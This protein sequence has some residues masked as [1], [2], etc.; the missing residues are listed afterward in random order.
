MVMF[1]LCL[2]AIARLVGS[3]T[4]SGI[5]KVWWR[6]MLAPGEHAATLRM[7]V[8]Y[9]VIVMGI[10]LVIVW[11][12]VH[13][14]ASMI[15]SYVDKSAFTF[16][17]C[18]TPTG[19]CPSD[20]YAR[21]QASSAARGASY[22]LHDEELAREKDVLAVINTALMA[23][24]IFQSLKGHRY[25]DP[26]CHHL[27][28][29]LIQLGLGRWIAQTLTLSYT[30]FLVFLGWSGL[31]ALSIV[32]AFVLISF[33]KQPRASRGVPAPVAHAVCAAPVAPQ[34]V[35]VAHA[36]CAAPS[37]PRSAPVPTLTLCCPLCHAPT[38]L[39][40]QDCPD[41]GLRFASRVPSVLH[42]LHG[43]TVLRPLS[44]GGMGNV[45]LAR[46]Q[47]TTEFC[48]I[49]TLAGVDGAPDPAWQTD[50]AQCL[51][52]EAAILARIDHP[53][54][55]RLLEAACQGA[56][57]YLA[58]EYI[59]GPSIAQRLSHTNPQGEFI[60]GTPMPLAEA[61]PLARSIAATLTD[62]AKLPGQLMH[63]DL[64]P[65]NLIVP[66]NRPAPVL[67]DFGSAAWAAATGAS[68]TRPLTIHG[69]PGYAAPEQYRGHASSQSDCYGLAA[70]LYHMLTDDDPGAH[71]LAF[72]ALPTLPVDIAALLM[73]ALDHNPCRR[74]P[75]CALS[76]GLEVLVAHYA[77]KAA[78]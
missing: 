63:L 75:M 27:C 5:P 34:L 3:P 55:P 28:R 6:D 45:Y 35:P 42:R 76:A 11:Y 38:D 21:Y 68:A 72:P 59:P 73:R 4:S 17:S 13:S 40:D 18:N 19:P 71:P 60:I 10:N 33:M 48:V 32:S 1:V 31:V 69:T 62:L 57:S 23:V 16:L 20:W 41:C 26:A 44:P 67:V 22:V 2:K 37:A 12:I 15:P 74:P 29:R 43:Y 7:I 39:Y 77:S 36:V 30:P 66:G 54:I 25:Q 61:L 78:R 53:H 14:P 64:K 70:T 50:A 9:H 46:A 47:H 49:K 8:L 58:L 56:F 51:A 52:R 65:G 24:V